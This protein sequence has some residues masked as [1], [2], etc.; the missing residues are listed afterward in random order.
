[1]MTFDDHLE[2]A[3][4]LHE[5]LPDGVDCLVLVCPLC[6]ERA[7]RPPM[8]TRDVMRWNLSAGDALDLA[9]LALAIAAL[10]VLDKATARVERWIDGAA[11]GSHVPE[12]RS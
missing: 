10:I 5:H 7:R 3:R 1:M 11:D 6:T 2:L 4:V 9:G 8:T 12:S